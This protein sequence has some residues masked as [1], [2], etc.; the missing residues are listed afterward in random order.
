LTNTIFIVS[1]KRKKNL[2]ITGVNYKF[3]KIHPK[4]M[5]GSTEIEVNDMIIKVSDKEKT[6]LDCMD[7]PEYCGGITE[8]IKGLWN[9]KGELDF[10]KMLNYAER[11]NNS[12][13]VKRLG[14]LMEI[15]E[16][17]KREFITTLRRMVRKGFS[18]LDPLLPKKGKFNSQWNLILN[19]SK[20]E[21]LSFKRK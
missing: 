9:A 16:L 4:K 5:F 7:H 20:E 14:Y 8:V 19:I 2:T 18:P 17:D 10:M 1:P 3:V 15:L 13:I 12:A 11:M 6:L 21:L